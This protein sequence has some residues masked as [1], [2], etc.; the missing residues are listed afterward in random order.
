VAADH[1]HWNAVVEKSYLDGLGLNWSNIR[2]VMDMRAV[3]GGYAHPLILKLLAG[4]FNNMHCAFKI[5]VLKY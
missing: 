1:N 4:L 5:H 2:N 3:Y